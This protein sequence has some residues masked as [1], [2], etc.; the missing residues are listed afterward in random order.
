[1]AEITR[2]RY[3]GGAGAVLGGLLAVACGEVEIRYVQGPA[4]PAGPAG[5]QGE[6]GATGAQGVQGESGAAGQTIV[7]DKPVTQVVEKTIVAAPNTKV[8]M[9][10]GFWRGG[11]MSDRGTGWTDLTN[12]W[13]AENLNIT[14]VL[15]PVAGQGKNTDEKIIS[16]YAA[17]TPPD[18]VH[19]A[20][21]SGGVYGIR[22]MLP[23]LMETFIRH[24]KMYADTMDD[25]FPHLLDSSYWNGQ[26]WSLPQETNADL[27]YTNL[28]FVREAG[29]EP[30][31]L[32]FTWDEWV[33][34]MKVMQTSLGDGK[35]TGKWAIGH[36]LNTVVWWNLVFQAG[37]SI[38]NEDRT[39]LVLDSPE[40]LEALQFV[41]D[42]HHKHQVAVPH[43]DYYKETGKER[44]SF[45]KGQI[46]QFYETS[47][48][49]LVTWA[50][51]IG[52][53]DNMYV[54]PSP[55]KKQ[56]FVANFGQNTY[57]FKTNT[58][59]MEAAWQV[60]RWLTS[61]DAAA[62][63]AAVTMFLAPRKSVLVHPEYQA[64][65]E[66]V[67][68]FET[69]VQ[70][71]SYGF[72]PFHPTLPS[73]FGGIGGMLSEAGKNPNANLKDG[74]A[75]MVRVENAKLAKWTADNA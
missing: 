26:L 67:P 32:G 41:S 63:Y 10:T 46:G 5:A 35:E 3:I 28:A 15:Q 12:R 44:P 57:L 60:M 65:R 37:G 18:L 52:G 29:L 48:S 17:G 19:T 2:R 61:T 73:M 42:I 30:L 55:T 25:F 16:N 54:T 62:H 34:W 27:P 24:D 36:M 11:N 49:R 38:F 72:R 1:M 6:R 8:V 39:K 50:Q 64:V 4:G 20:Y 7:V 75:E 66:R 58:Q 51:D 22:D 14:F 53:L 59:Q 31:T 56:P 40:A 13:N 45:R 9:W 47:A 23:E 33:E 70:S 21:W 74:L 71:L 68:Q 43:G 69:F